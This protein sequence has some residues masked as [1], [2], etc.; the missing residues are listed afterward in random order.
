M[1]QSDLHIVARELQIRNDPVINLIR[2]LGSA[3]NPHV[4][5]GRHELVDNQVFE[6]DL[7]CQFSNSV[8]QVFPL[9]VDHIRNIVQVPLNLR[10]LPLNLVNLLFLN[11][12]FILLG[13]EVLMQ[14]NFV[15]LLRF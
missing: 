1:L 6:P 2:P 11:I 7:P 4:L 5:L 9:S 8:H 13:T 10:I 14:V 3:F 15:V 12:Q